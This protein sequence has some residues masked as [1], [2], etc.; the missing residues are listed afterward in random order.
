[1]GEQ[2]WNQP[3]LK[4]GSVRGVVFYKYQLLDPFSDGAQ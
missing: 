3:V 1:M 2:C 4:S